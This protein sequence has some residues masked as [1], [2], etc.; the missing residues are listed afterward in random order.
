MTGPVGGNRE[1]QIQQW[2]KAKFAELDAAD[3]KVDRQIKRD[4]WNSFVGSIGTGRTINVFI[5]EDNAMKSLR[6][7]ARRADAG[8]INNNQTLLDEL[9]SFAESGEISHDGAASNS[10]PIEAEAASKKLSSSLDSFTMPEGLESGAKFDAAKVKENI[11]GAYAPEFSLNGA[12]KPPSEAESSVSLLLEA[13]HNAESLS[14]KQRIVFAIKNV[15]AQYPEGTICGHKCSDIAKFDNIK[16]LQLFQVGQSGVIGQE[17]TDPANSSD[18][19]IKTLHSNVSKAQQFIQDNLGNMSD[20]ELAQIGMSR[21]KCDRI[22]KYISSIRYENDEFHDTMHGSDEGTIWVNSKLNG[23]ENIENM[24]CMLM[25]EANHCDEAY[26]REFPGESEVGDLRHRNSEGDAVRSPMFNTRE[27]ELACERL[28]VLTTAN[29]IKSGVLKDT[30]YGR[31]PEPGYGGKSTG[32]RHAFIDYLN[33]P[34]GMKLLDKD[35]QGWVNTGYTNYPN[36]FD[37]SITLQACGIPRHYGSE[38][39][40][41]NRSETKIELTSGCN[42]KIGNEDYTLGSDRC[43]NGV[44]SS[45]IFSLSG[46]DGLIILDDLPPADGVKKGVGKDNLVKTDTKVVITDKNGVQHTGYLYKESL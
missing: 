15:A 22:L 20:A 43:L 2:A 45:E 4:V 21:D 17:I 3:G 38:S 39:E 41:N 30:N 44:D 37:G 31:Y 13:M 1:Q 42:I 11:Q 28:G 18:P 24:V 7:Y 14:D 27:E 25:H 12:G 29:L 26:L 40:Y 19:K 10:G 5:N 6:T 35:L 8:T 32:D 46:V 23:S 16:I 9:N 34:D 33:K 36:N